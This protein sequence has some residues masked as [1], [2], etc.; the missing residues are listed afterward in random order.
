LAWEKETYEEEFGIRKPKTHQYLA[1]IGPK[2]SGGGIFN[3]VA[4]FYEETYGSPLSDGSSVGGLKTAV[5]RVLRQYRLPGTKH[6]SLRHGQSTQSLVYSEEIALPPLLVGEA[7]KYLLVGGANISALAKLH[8]YGLLPEN[9]LL[10]D[11]KPSQLSEVREYIRQKIA[12]ANGSPS[13]AV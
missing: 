6:I 5:N 10:P 4:A 7:K 2:M 9:L 8:N 13:P 3:S 12:I 1:A 11:Q